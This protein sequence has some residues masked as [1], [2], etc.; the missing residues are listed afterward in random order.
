MQSACQVWQEIFASSLLAEPTFS[1]D[2][3]WRQ[4]AAVG[5]GKVR[6]AV[7]AAVAAN[8]AV[9]RA[10]KTL[11][12]FLH[13]YAP[14]TIHA[15][16]L[17]TVPTSMHIIHASCNSFNQYYCWSSFLLKHIRSLCV[18][19]P[20]PAPIASTGESSIAL[21][22][23]SKGS[24]K[25]P[26]II[27]GQSTIVV[28]VTHGAVASFGRKR[29]RCTWQLDD[30]MHHLWLGKASAGAARN[31]VVAIRVRAPTWLSRARVVKVS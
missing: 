18:R 8:S 14:H 3:R 19:S 6:P 25:A 27:D 20:S 28:V 1:A 26:T 2:L 24:I 30:A 17:R 7:A 4:Y 9:G 23:V 5:P 12:L 10:R 13:T 22:Y 16:I 31:V 21:S 11:T 15:Y 29:A